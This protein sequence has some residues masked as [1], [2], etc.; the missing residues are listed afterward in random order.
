MGNEKERTNKMRE[1][2]ADMIGENPELADEYFAARK[3]RR[4]ADQ[5]QYGRLGCQDE[6]E[7]KH[8]DF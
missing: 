4:G 2:I 8:Q 3:R 1:F 7:L 5:R 6:R